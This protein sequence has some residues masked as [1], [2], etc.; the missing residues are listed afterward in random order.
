[1]AIFSQTSDKSGATI[2]NQAQNPAATPFLRAKTK[3]ARAIL[4]IAAALGVA[5]FAGCS[6]S[7][8]YYE[9]ASEIRTTNDF[10]ATLPADIIYKTADGATLDNGKFL[11]KKGQVS[12]LKL[13]E[14]ERFL[15]TYGAL[16]VV[17]GLDGTLKI[18]NQNRVQFTTKLDSMPIS[19]STNGNY[20]AAISAANTIFLIN[21]STG[22]IA[23][24]YKQNSVFSQDSATVAPLFSGGEVIFATLDGKVIAVSLARATITR[25][26]VVG[27]EYF[28]NNI[29]ALGTTFSGDIIG[30]TST[31]VGVLKG[32]SVKYFD[33][34]IKSAII[35]GESVFLFLKNGEVVRLSAAGSSLSQTAKTTFKYAIFTGAARVGELIYAFE[36]NGYVFA[37]DAALNTRKIY[38]LGRKLDEITFIGEGRLYCED[39]ML[40][41]KSLR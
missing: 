38:K 28:F 32:R 37:L 2:Q 27:G 36:K 8:Q 22:E 3:T 12:T 19:A 14:N 21:V 13:A 35:D 20:L 39:E 24:Q 4:C 16:D 30:V 5:A 31:R 9:P 25:D 10:R 23:L 7:R 41:L 40:D 17:A 18:Y 11:N 33:A 1:M 34:Q 26:F 29:I 15:G 6:T